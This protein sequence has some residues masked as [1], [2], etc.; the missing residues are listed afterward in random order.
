ML[1]ASCRGRARVTT[2]IA[3]KCANLRRAYI[4]QI[5]VCRIQMRCACERPRVRLRVR[6]GRCSIHG[7]CL[8]GETAAGSSMLRAA[9]QCN[10][11]IL[12]SNPQFLPLAAPVPPRL[13]RAVPS[14]IP[15][16]IV[17]GYRQKADCIHPHTYT[18]IHIYI[19]IY[20]SAVDASRPRG[21][22]S[23]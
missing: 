10:Y 3:S 17:A 13:K 23:R 9:A 16:P 22:A 18:Y 21:G 14:P 4:A 5:S 19:C 2:C 7:M 8:A 1:P 6:C 15:L 12:A 20:I 11:H